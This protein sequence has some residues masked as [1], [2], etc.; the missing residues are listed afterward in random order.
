MDRAEL[1]K[2]QERMAERNQA[3]RENTLTSV[4]KLISTGKIEEAKAEAMRVSKH[5]IFDEMAEII[6]GEEPEIVCKGCGVHLRSD[7]YPMALKWLT[8][9]CAPCSEKAEK[10][11][12]RLRIRSFKAEVLSGIDKH[13]ERAGVP[14]RFRSALLSDFPAKMAGMATS[15]NGWF[16]T[17]ERGTGK[18]HLAA[19]VVR[20]H[21]LALEPDKGRREDWETVYIEYPVFVPVTEILLEIRD[22]FNSRAENSNT[23]RAVIEKYSSCPLLVLDDLGVEKSTEWSMQTLYTL[24]DRRYRDERRTIVTSNL[25]L[26]EIA[27]RVDD[28][29]ASRIAGMCKIQ[30]L[31]GKDRRTMKREE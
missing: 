9:N 12:E 22:T 15:K 27:S 23:E 29:I 24:I 31:K 11:K 10:E 17:G 2:I 3:L 25:S 19:A 8:A 18:T 1:I 6:K 7:W 26:D 28:R 20:E 16:I 5:P 4:R 21:L 13:M 30:E 14:K